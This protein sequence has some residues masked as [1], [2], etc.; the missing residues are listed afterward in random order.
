MI[1]SQTIFLAL[2]LSG[3][4]WAIASIQSRKVVTF[5]GVF[6]YRTVFK[7]LPA[8]FF[9]IAMLVTGIILCLKG[10]DVPLVSQLPFLY[11]MLF[12]VGAFLVSL[13]VQFIQ[14]QGEEK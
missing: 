9:A 7:G 11:I 4:I 14:N 6:N 2:G 8:L 3:V 12:Y 13:I 10:L 5:A 1:I